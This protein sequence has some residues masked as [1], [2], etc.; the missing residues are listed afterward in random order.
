MN[1]SSCWICYGLAS[2][3]LLGSAGD[4]SARLNSGM[5][6]RYMQQQQKMQQQYM[7]MEQKMMMEAMARQAA[8]EKQRRETLAKA[9]KA[10]SDKEEEHR[11]YL[12]SKRK[13]EQA[14][15]ATSTQDASTPKK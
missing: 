6:R 15:R 9:S 1:R 10:R 3:I 4:A 13:S 11:Q 14:A 7:Q 5:F 8:M 2:A 12:I